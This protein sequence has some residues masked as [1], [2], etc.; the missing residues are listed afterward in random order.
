M[1]PSLPSKVVSTLLLA[2]WEPLCILIPAP[3]VPYPSCPQSCKESRFPVFVSHRAPA[4]HTASSLIASTYPF[5]FFPFFLQSF[6][7]SCLPQ[8]SPHVNF[9]SLCVCRRMHTYL[10]LCTCM[11]STCIR[12]FFN[13]SLLLNF[14]VSGSLPECGAH[15]FS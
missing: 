5:T 14:F 8:C 3:S 11:W 10:C 1:L 9:F 6:A 13:H 2:M 7:H 15:G 4:T 12:I